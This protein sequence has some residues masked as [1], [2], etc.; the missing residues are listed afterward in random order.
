MQRRR[1]APRS[2][3]TVTRFL[4]VAVLA[5]IAA[6]GAT[7]AVAQ[8]TKPGITL[9][10]SPASQSVTRGQQAT[11]TVTTTSTGG[12][13]GSV[14]LTVSGLPNSSSAVFAPASV[15]LGSGG[16]ATSTMTV[17][18]TSSTSVSSFT[19]TVTGTSGKVNGSVQAGLTV[20][21]P[22]SGSITMSATP[23]SVTMAP[24]ATAVYSI[25][26][27]RTSLTNAVTFT[28]SGGLPSH[29]TA[30]YSPSST[31]GNSSSLQITTLANTPEGTYTLYLVASGN[32]SA[33]TTRYAYASVQLVIAT[34]GK[35][36][37]I[38]GNLTGLLAPGVSLPLDL[39]LTNPNNQTISI[40]NLTVTVQ[41]V[42]KV[43][44]TRVGSCSTA[45]YVVTQ[46]SGPYPLA[47]PAHGSATLSSL[48]VAA[49][50]QPHVKMIDTATNQDGC[51]SATLTLAYSGSGQGS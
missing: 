14:A 30:T 38:S 35:P 50:L 37:A 36:F 12:F 34:G 21:Y 45:D 18:T 46:Y 13:T 33:G 1:F 48:G 6:A 44:P 27:T 8:A 39:T 23:G 16:N 7:I 19:L 42:A 10:I 28:V 25:A 4:V 51:K 22:A 2:A 11:Y 32:D 9:Q 5:L 15:T 40:S 29:A 20:N 24:A 43:P 47:V 31:T 17:S 3:R 26:L 41:S 49:E